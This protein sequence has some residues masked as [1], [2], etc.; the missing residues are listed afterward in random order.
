MDD[1]I[2]VP[3][4]VWRHLVERITPKGTVK[5]SDLLWAIRKADEK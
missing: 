4:D 3:E 5:A 2:P 1:A